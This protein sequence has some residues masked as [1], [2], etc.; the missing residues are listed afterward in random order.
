LEPNDL[1]LKSLKI[2]TSTWT[3]LGVQFFSCGLLNY[4]AK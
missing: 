3:N 1:G 2:E 4:L